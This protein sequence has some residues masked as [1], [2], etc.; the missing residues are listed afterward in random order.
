M[1][2]ERKGQKSEHYKAF[3][4]VYYAGRAMLHDERINPVYLIT[5]V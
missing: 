2:V 1:L 4:H 5:D 3:C